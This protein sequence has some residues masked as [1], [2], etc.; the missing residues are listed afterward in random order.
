MGFMFLQDHMLF[1]LV[2]RSLSGNITGNNG[3]IN[4]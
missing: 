2:F 4:L 1:D 3:V